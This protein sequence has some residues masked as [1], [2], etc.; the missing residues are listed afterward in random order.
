[1]D[2]EN[3]ELKDSTFDAVIPRLGLMFF[4]NLQRSLEEIG[5]V[6]KPG[7]DYLKGGLGR[8]SPSA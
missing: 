3:L 6:L 4:P 8:H 1:M 5:L 7:G 2:G